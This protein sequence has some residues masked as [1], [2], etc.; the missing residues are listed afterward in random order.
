[1]LW[2]LMPLE[3]PGDFPVTTDGTSAPVAD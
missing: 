2:I 1:M 3:R